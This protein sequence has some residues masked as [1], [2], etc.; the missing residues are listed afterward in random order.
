M[1]KKAVLQ[2]RCSQSAVATLTDDKP[3]TGKERRRE[4][5]HLD[6]APHSGLAQGRTSDAKPGSF[7][8]ASGQQNVRRDEL[9][10]TQRVPGY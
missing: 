9:L 10:H 7:L 5:G 2:A 4:G 3:M 6:A 1:A 8:R